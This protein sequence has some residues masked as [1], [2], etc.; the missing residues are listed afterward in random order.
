MFRCG[1]LHAHLSDDP[2]SLDLGVMLTSCSDLRLDPKTTAADSVNKAVKQKADKLKDLNTGIVEVLW[3]TEWELAKAYEL[4]RA[5]EK[6]CAQPVANGET[7]TVRDSV[8]ANAE[9][10]HTLLIMLASKLPPNAAHATDNSLRLW[11]ASLRG[12]GEEDAEELLHQG[13]RWRAV[14]AGEVAGKDGLRLSDYVGAA[15]SVSQKLRQIAVQAARRFAWLLALAVLVALGGVALI[16]LDTKG[17][18]GAGIA[19]VLAAFGV[20]WKGIGEF[21]GRVAAKGEE[22]LWAA[23]L[24]WA[25]AY[26]FTAL[27]NPAT[28]RKLSR[29][30]KFMGDDR[31]MKAHLVRY[32]EWKANWPDVDLTAET[33]RSDA[34]AA[35]AKR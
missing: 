1:Q 28:G 27:S 19:A 2:T 15:D 12:G 31:P 30:S 3:A 8:A 33:I 7:I 22:Q 5:M 13:W 29:W 4:G 17:S 20:T 11:S 25:I 34:A 9:N 35:A 26:R 21:F 16:F 24:D 23:E 6:M 14:L 10:V 32:N 18:V